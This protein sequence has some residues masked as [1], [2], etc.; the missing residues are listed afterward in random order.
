MKI[1]VKR[2][3]VRACPQRHY[4]KG[5]CKKHYTQLTRHGKLT[6]DRERGRLHSCSSPGCDKPGNVGRN[7]TYCKKHAHQVR[8]HGQLT[9]GR[10][11]AYGVHQ[12]CSHPGCTQPHRAK[13]YC[14]KHYN[15]ARWK[16]I[17]A[18]VDAQQEPATA[19]AFGDPGGPSTAPGELS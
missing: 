15:A 7:G 19:P 17:K 1:V 12:K 3:S 18:A 5:F 6:P 16:K 11:H 14:T 8:K 2:C 10:E 9:P 13:G 4:G